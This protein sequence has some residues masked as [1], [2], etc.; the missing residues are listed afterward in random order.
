MEC[1]ITVFKKQLYNGGVRSTYCAFT[2]YPSVSI[3]NDPPLSSKIFAKNTRG[4]KIGEIQP[5]D[6][7]L[8][9]DPGDRMEITYQKIIFDRIHN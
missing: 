3:E 8:S 4:I 2:S 5:F 1:G 6:R 9:G 7:L